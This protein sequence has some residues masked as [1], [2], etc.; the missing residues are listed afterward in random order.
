MFKVFN[1]LKDRLSTPC[2]LRFLEGWTKRSC[3]TSEWMDFS[4]CYLLV[5][6]QFCITQMIRELNRINYFFLGII[7]GLQL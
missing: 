4:V 6:S 7:V 5:F 2:G 3:L 1:I